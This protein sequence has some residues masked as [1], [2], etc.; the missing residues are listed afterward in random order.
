VTG[1]IQGSVR[2][3]FITQAQLQV[4][5][6]QALSNRVR[7]RMARAAEVVEVRERI[8]AVLAELLP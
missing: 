6:M 1:Q 4:F 2:H 5:A 7:T 8:T 3:F